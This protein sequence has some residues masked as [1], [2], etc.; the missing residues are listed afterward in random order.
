MVRKEIRDHANPTDNAIA[1]A[2]RAQRSNSILFHTISR[3]QQGSITAEDDGQNARRSFP[4]IGR[5]LLFAVERE[6]GAQ[7]FWSNTEKA[8]SL[9]FVAL[10]GG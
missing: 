1:E 7:S 10:A 4:T 2:D 9:G 3:P 8:R 5:V 6:L